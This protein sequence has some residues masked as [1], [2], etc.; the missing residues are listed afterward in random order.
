MATEDT[1]LQIDNVPKLETAKQR[2]VAS[3]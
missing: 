1:D 3:G 2:A